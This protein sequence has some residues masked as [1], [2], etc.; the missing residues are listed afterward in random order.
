MDRRVRL[1]TEYVRGAR[2][3]R[4]RGIPKR[5]PGRRVAG[6]HR[7]FIVD[8]HSFMR[9]AAAAWIERCA[10]L[11]VCGMTGAPTEALRS[12]GRLRP[13]VVVSE[14]MRPPDLK[15]VRLLRRRHPRL[16]ILVFSFWNQA[17]FGPRASA[18][19]A[20]GFLA[21]EAGGERLVRAIRALVGG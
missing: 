13:D 14:I 17:A 8:P 16:P 2:Q 10:D 5:A 15:F 3:R 7:V 9:Q 18:A 4:A 19:G 1:Q 20:S 21:K 11:E 12:V 6:P